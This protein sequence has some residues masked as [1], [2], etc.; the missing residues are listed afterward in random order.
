MVL[1]AIR[2]LER[3]TFEG[4]QQN[5]DRGGPGSPPAARARSA[6]TGGSSPARWSTRRSRRPRELRPA[7]TA[8]P[9][10][11]TPPTAPRPG[12]RRHGSTSSSGNA[13]LD[14]THPQSA[15]IERSLHGW[16]SA[17]R[18]PDGALTCAQT[19]ASVCWARYECSRFRAGAGRAS[20]MA[21]EQPRADDVVAW[22]ELSGSGSA[23]ADG[24]TAAQVLASFEL[25]AST[26]RVEL[27]DRHLRTPCALS[28]RWCEHER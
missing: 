4:S 13:K 9:P 7:G 17:P 2:E 26:R 20:A 5:R 23:P 11:L 27:G 1:W 25:L 10:R 22:P 24:A 28:A 6:G 18:R 14:R 8:S 21:T 16:L 3:H 15:N 12:T 19:R